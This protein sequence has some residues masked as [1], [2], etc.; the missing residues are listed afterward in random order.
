ML[1]GAR[2][3]TCDEEGAEPRSGD[4]VT[5][6]LFRKGSAG[7]GKALEAGRQI[8][9]NKGH[10]EPKQRSKRNWEDWRWTA[11]RASLPILFSVL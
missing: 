1:F 5:G 4:G 6:K 9:V 2:R 3:K 11:G 10:C 7:A 8:R